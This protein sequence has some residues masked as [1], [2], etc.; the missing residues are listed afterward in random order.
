MLA[1]IVRFAIRFRGVVVAVALL[2]LG[3]G[4]FA[5]LRSRLDV[6]PE[7]SPP[8][9][10]VQ[11]ESPGLSP[12]Q[13]ELL[14]T[15]PVE[16]ALLGLTDLKTIRSRSFQGLSMVTMTFADGTDIYRDRQEVAERLAT[17][18]TE[19]PQ[20]VERPALLP[21]TS[22]T[23]VVLSVGL[24]SRTR[25]LMELRTL[26][27]WTV[28]PHLLSVPG[29]A[30]VSVFGGQERQLQV[31]VRP[32]RLFRYGLSLAQV[33][34]A[35]RRSTALHGAGFI[36]NANQRMVLA[37][38]GQ[39]SSASQVGET[40]LRH[41]EGITVRL[42]DVARVTDGPAPPLG[43]ASVMGQSGVMLVVE[44]QYGADTMGVTRALDKALDQLRPLLAREKVTLHPD[45]FRPANFIETAIGH[46]RLALLIGAG[47]VVGVLFLFLFNV[48]TA[49]ISAAA[50]PLS[51]LTA[52]AVL[53]H[54]GI[55]LNTMTLGGLAIAIGEVVDDAIIDVENIFRRLRE[56][57]HSEAPRRA[58]QVVL[59]ASLEVRSAVIYATFAVAL[60]FLPI[61]TLSG[62]AGRLFGPLGL[63]YILAILAS[64]LVALT[65]TPALSFLL[66]RRLPP[67]AAEP[68]VVRFLK[69]RYVRMLDAVEVKAGVVFAVAA[70]LCLGAFALL[71]FTEGEFLPQLREGHFIVHMRAVPGTSLAQSLELGKR[72][73]EA[74]LMIPGVRS[75]AQRAGRA[76]KISDPQGVFSSELDVDLKPLSGSG[77]QRVLD[78]LRNT[79]DRFAGARSA[80][81]TFLTERI[82]ETISGQ[83]APV[84]VNIFGQD[85]AAIDRVARQVA[86]ILGGIP[87]ASG[88]QVQAPPGS[89]QLTMRLREQELSRW[90]ISP[91]DAL[92][93]VRT[94][95]AGVDVAQVYEGNRFFPVTVVL[96][97]EL[98]QDPT[99]VGDLLLRSPEGTSIPLGSLADISLSQGPYVILHS[100][101]Q[102]LQTVTADVR[103][104]SLGSL[105]AEARRRLATQLT[106]PSGTYLAFSG[107][108]AER[109]RAQRD[110]LVH[111]ALAGGAILILLFIAFGSLRS[112]LLVAANLPFA[113]VGGILMVWFSGRTFSIGSLVGFVTLFGITLRNSIMLI[114]H[115]E[116]LVR[117]EGMA[118]GM[119]AAIRGASERLAPILMTATVTALGLLPLAVTSGAPGNEIEGPMALVILGG[120]VTSTLLNL[121]VLPSLALRYGRFGVKDEAD[122]PE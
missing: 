111:S 93:A 87:G 63:A 27:D 79:L 66:L 85:P 62:V 39:P 114:S 36:E 88:V 58:T 69:A 101:G 54:L 2:W 5:L 53:R 44:E 121:L 106:L 14:V 94:A 3:Y 29:V 47:L 15:T 8:L 89:P 72:A 80:V 108:I 61:L 11:T 46:L 59:E 100:G 45:L 43:A 118:W 110:L 20:G 9:V 112:L 40:V 86:A 24:T 75:V 4:L 32:D 107:D 83:L 68:P 109:S 38:Q 115:Y 105:V 6:F 74:V 60:V 73:T 90:G 42:G 95:F 22:A 64:L 99:Q 41:R 122:E 70:V 92:E 120:L 31:Q 84:V 81:N 104:R 117:Q 78:A 10:M 119:E 56:N 7:F 48:R 26:A 17:V 77:Q 21:L 51:L 37:P 30:D 103:G 55:G 57:S 28:K 34:D 65:L 113:L 13:V 12:R 97:P 35:A 18:T 67:T 102:R 33:V 19:L 96:A 23:Q 91:A 49:A 116:H 25:S 16:N 76:E 82:H 52:V 98:R 50:I 71:P 1:G